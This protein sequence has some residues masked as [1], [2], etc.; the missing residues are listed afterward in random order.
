M[1]QP[2]YF[3]ADLVKVKTLLYDWKM[4][5]SEATAKERKE[6]VASMFGEVRV[7]TRPSLRPR[8][9]T[10]PTRRSSPVPRRTV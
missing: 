7:A 10:Q 9:L 1:E 3:E 6:I 5:W 4:L 2:S 8:S